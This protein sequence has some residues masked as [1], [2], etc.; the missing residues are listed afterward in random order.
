MVFHLT[1]QTKN[2]YVVSAGFAYSFSN[3]CFL[4]GAKIERN[5][6]AHIESTVLLK[7]YDVLRFSSTYDL[8]NIQ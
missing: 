4:L 6:F 3:S 8:L 5:D 1:K 2:V 7:Y